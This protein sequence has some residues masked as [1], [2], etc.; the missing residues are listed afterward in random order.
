[1]FLDTMEKVLGG[2]AEVPGRVA[3]S[4]SG[5][6]GTTPAAAAPAPAV[7]PWSMN[8]GATAGAGAAAAGVVPVLPLQEFATRPGTSAQGSGPAG[9]ARP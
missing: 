9:S 6:T 8:Q 2:G 5:R 3:N 4:C 1:M 7:A